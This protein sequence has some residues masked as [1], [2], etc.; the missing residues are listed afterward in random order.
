MNR[1]IEKGKRVCQPKEFDCGFKC[2]PKLVVC[3]GIQDCSNALDESNCSKYQCE[4]IV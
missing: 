1:F 3:D 4:I 2:I